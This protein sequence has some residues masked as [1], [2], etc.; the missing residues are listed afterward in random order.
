[1]NDVNLENVDHETAVAT[2]KATKQNVK[3]VIGRPAYSEVDGLTAP[4]VA[5]TTTTTKTVKGIKVE[6][7]SVLQLKFVAPFE[8]LRFTAGHHHHAVE[9]QRNDVMTCWS[10]HCILV[11]F[12]E[13][14]AAACHV[15]LHPFKSCCV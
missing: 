9:P 2:L 6:S 4:V 1:V 7:K 14:F 10:S 12:L 8:I 15:Y 11:D 5:T 13:S 3:L